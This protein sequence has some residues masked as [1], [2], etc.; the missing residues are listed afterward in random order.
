MHPVEIVP[1]P[2]GAREVIYAASQPEYR[3]LITVRFDDGCVISRWS[4]SWREKLSVLLGSGI[5]VSKLTF[6]Q[7]LQPMKVGISVDDVQ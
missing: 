3:P 1:L 2:E 4:L 6:N 5:Y 7:S